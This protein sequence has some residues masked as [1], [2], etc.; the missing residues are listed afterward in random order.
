MW[1]GQQ[2]E[3]KWGKRYNYEMGLQ[4]KKYKNREMLGENLV[5]NPI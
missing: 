2:E 4:V 5:K 1:W 3:E